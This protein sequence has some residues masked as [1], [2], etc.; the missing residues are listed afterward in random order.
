MAMMNCPECG[1]QISTDAVMCP[2]CGK[3]IKGTGLEA[4]AGK[5]GTAI[6]AIIFI[7]VPIAFVIWLVSSIVS[8]AAH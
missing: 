8:C 7:G 2:K 5:G 6:G 3:K 1:N 4:V